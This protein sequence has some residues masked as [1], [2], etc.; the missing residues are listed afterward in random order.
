MNQAL[1]RMALAL[2]MSGSAAGC[3][4][5]GSGG[6]VPPTLTGLVISPQS[7]T[8]D[9]A[10]SQRFTV[11]ASYS[12]GSNQ[13]VN[14]TWS[15]TNGTI[16]QNGF[17]RPSQVVAPSLVIA[18]LQNGTIADTA[19][20]EVTALPPPNP[21]YPH[22]PAGF[23][24]VTERS[25]AALSEDGWD[26][27]PASGSD[28][29]FS[30]KSD[31]LAPKSPPGVGQVFYPAGF[32][33][34]GEPVNVFKYGFPANQRLY[35]SF[36]VRF[37][38]NWVGH[39]SGVNKIFHFIINNINKVFLSA[40]GADNDNLVATVFLQQIPGVD[41]RRLD[42]DLN[43]G[44]AQIVRGRWHRWELLLT[45][46]TIGSFNGTAEWWIDGVR[47]GSYSD[48]AYI[49]SGETTTWDGI[50]WAPTWGGGPVTL[51][52]AQN[53]QIDHVYISGAP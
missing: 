30:I 37:S 48:I 24:K 26:V 46:N 35:I 40:Q 20:V 34:G 38:P 39:P 14:V 51:Q 33:G 50:Q 32:Q 29:N 21:N 17:Y 13:A 5:G 2:T 16:D 27:A 23:T 25:F 53:E 47:V 11:V 49:A 36:W 8:V 22:E 31:A 12:D 45:T 43:T 10:G 44:S 19:N 52:V 28:T 7:T 15:T 42:P 1:M 4:G 41:G 6:M 9:T 18:K 3:G